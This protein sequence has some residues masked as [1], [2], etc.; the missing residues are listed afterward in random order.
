MEC[1]WDVVVSCFFTMQVPLEELVSYLTAASI[2]QMSEV[3]DK[4]T[5]AV[6]QFLKPI[7]FSNKPERHSKEIENQQPDESWLCSSFENQKEKDVAQP[8][9]TIQEDRTK[10]EGVV[11]GRAMYGVSQE[12]EVDN[13]STTD[14]TEDMKF[15][16]STME[17]SEDQRFHLDALIAEQIVE[18]TSAVVK[19]EVLQD[20]ISFPA[21]EVKA[22]ADHVK[23]VDISKKQQDQVGNE[24]KQ[25]NHELQAQQEHAG[26]PMDS[27][28]PNHSG[29][30]LTKTA[31]DMQEA[32]SGVLAE[33]PYLCIKCD[34]IFQHPEN[35]VGHLKEHRQYSCLVCGEGFSQKNKLTQHIR[36]HPHIKPL[37][38]PLCHE[39]F[40]QKSLLQEHLHLHTGYKYNL[41][42]ANKSDFRDLKRERNGKKGLTDVLEEGGGAG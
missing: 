37:R 27:T 24:A 2:L 25:S 40:I 20:L 16:E 13:E 10:D 15:V 14:T 1:N 11:L 28:I 19:D 32:S 34:K 22:A 12:S 4:C 8:T 5:Q 17:S 30:Q 41:N 6:S 7:M 33:R 9:T 42:P 29:A 26:G 18:N 38:C 36:V 23:L 21:Y 31:E 35:Y 3:V 39:K